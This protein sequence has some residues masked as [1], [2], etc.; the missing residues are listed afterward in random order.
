MEPTILGFHWKT[1]KRSGNF[2]LAHQ[3]R[4]FG[5]C[6]SEM[7]PKVVRKV[8]KRLYAS[9]I[10]VFVKIKKKKQLKLLKPVKM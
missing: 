6:E 5:F 2:Q 9:I 3:L 8:I 10:L 1:S 7:V 4:K